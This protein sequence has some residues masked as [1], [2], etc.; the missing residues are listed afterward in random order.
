[1]IKNKIFQDCFS[2]CGILQQKNEKNLDLKDL[3][4]QKFKILIKKLSQI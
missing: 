2:N 4:L 3:P 1:M